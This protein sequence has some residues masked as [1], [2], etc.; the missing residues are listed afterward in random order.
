MPVQFDTSVLSPALRFPHWQRSVSELFVRLDVTSQAAEGFHMKV[1]RTMLGT[2]MYARNTGSQ[3][4]LFRK[5]SH[6]ERGS[7]DVLVFLL[8]NQGRTAVVQDDREAVLEPG[9]FAMFDA[10]RAY[11]LKMSG[12]NTHTVLQVPR[13]LLN[14]RIA[15]SDRYTALP[16]APA[17]PLARL[18]FD[19]VVNVSNVADDIG[20][21]YAG[22][23]SE[24]AL[25]LLAMA[26]CERLDDEPLDSTTH[27]S[28]M[29]YRLKTYVQTHLADPELSIAQVASA[30]DISTRYVNNLLAD[31]ATSFRR[32]LLERR[33]EQCRRDLSS[34]RLAHRQIGEIAYA[35]GFNDLA[36]FSRAFKESYGAS[37]RSF[38]QA[39]LLS[40]PEAPQPIGGLRV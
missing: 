36:H 3:Q 11:E 30:M 31:E 6:I 22:A 37:P 17:R 13:A 7:E 19:F 12:E 20:A 28:A 26:L 23:L 25:D 8:A 21:G 9:E 5:A 29:L 15:R 39:M 4:H 1:S 14:K 32:H 2:V 18:A 16:F 38:R 35:W 34:A 24:Q 40:S 27:R 10:T 33:L